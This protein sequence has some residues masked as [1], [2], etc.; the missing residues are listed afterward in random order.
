M[1]QLSTKFFFRKPEP[2]IQCHTPPIRCFYALTLCA[3]QI[4]LRFLRYTVHS[5]EHVVCHDATIQQVN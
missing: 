1:F 3:L 2:A 5:T 4:V